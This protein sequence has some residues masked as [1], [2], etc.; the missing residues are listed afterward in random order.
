MLGLL[1]YAICKNGCDD[2]PEERR[3]PRDHVDD[4][5]KG[6]LWFELLKRK[7]ELVVIEYAC[8]WVVVPILRRQESRIVE[9]SQIGPWMMTA[10]WTPNSLSSMAIVSA[11]ALIAC[12]EAA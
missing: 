8:R 2:I 6:S 5:A 12:F 10:T 3:I 9:A 4:A 7:R 1:A 11:I